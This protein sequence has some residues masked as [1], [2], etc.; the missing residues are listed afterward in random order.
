VA[1][2]VRPAGSVLVVAALTRFA[3]ILTGWGCYDDGNQSRS[4]GLPDDSGSR[5]RSA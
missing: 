5:L 1:L 3:A 2:A 4:S